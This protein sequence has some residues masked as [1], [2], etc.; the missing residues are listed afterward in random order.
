MKMK[1]NYSEKQK[2]EIIS[3]YLSGNSVTKLSAE[4]HI[5][6]STIYEWIK[7]SAECEK[8]ER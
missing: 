5:A 3:R 1:K 6:Q 7:E 4:Y 8:Q 2:S